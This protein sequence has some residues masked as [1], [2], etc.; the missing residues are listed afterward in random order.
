M[1]IWGKCHVCS[2]CFYFSPGI[3]L[4]PLIERGYCAS[5]VVDLNGCGCL[6]A[7][8]LSATDTHRVFSPILGWAF[9]CE[10][11]HQEEHNLCHAHMLAQLHLH[12]C[13]S[14][15]LSCRNNGSWYRARRKERQGSARQE[16]QKETDSCST[17]LLKC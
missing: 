12:P 1:R 6:C 16:A 10:S 7:F 4:W 5:S 2:S 17:E 13:P 9:L 8:M 14:L 11:P 15:P 3:H